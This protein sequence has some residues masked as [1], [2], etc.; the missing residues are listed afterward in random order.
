[1][2]KAE[3]L[4]DVWGP[5]LSFDSP[6]EPWIPCKMSNCNWQKWAPRDEEHPGMQGPNQAAGEA[7]ATTEAGPSYSFFH[8]VVLHPWSFLFISKIT[9]KT[10]K[11]VAVVSGLFLQTSCEFYLSISVILST[12]AG[13]PMLIIDEKLLWF[14]LLHVCYQ[15]LPKVSTLTSTW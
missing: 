15:M 12:V 1:M 3:K 2:R 8:L 7:S 13:C 14:V 10:S 6:L 4:S 11:V 9:D 5:M